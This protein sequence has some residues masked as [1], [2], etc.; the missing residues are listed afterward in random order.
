[1]FFLFK[2]AISNDKGLPLIKN[3]C[4]NLLLLD[5]FQLL[6]VSIPNRI[7]FQVLQAVL[8]KVFSSIQ[9]FDNQYMVSAIFTVFNLNS[10]HQLGL[11][12]G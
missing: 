2:K 3:Y 10:C 5:L 11:E 8:I 12:Y 4:P 1:M 6:H 9:P 7:K